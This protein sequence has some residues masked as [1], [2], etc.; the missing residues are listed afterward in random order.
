VAVRYWFHVPTDALGRTFV[1]H[2]EIFPG[3]VPA[4]HGQNLIKDQAQVRSLAAWLS[5]QDEAGTLGRY[6]ERPDG[7]PEDGVVAATTEG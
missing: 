3:L 7:L 2:A 6:F 4:R 5:E 1:L